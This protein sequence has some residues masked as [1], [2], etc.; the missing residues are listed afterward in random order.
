VRSG[1]IVFAKLRY[2]PR[3]ATFAAC[4]PRALRVFAGSLLIVR[5]LFAAAAAFATFRRAAAF[6]FEL[7]KAGA[8]I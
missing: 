3:R 4:L 8:A 2:F 6:C 5:F 7:A 1:S